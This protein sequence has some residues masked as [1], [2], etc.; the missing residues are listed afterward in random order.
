VTLAAR[1]AGLD[2]ERAA[3]LAVTPRKPQ[4]TQHPH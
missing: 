3:A 2:A 4:H 1:G